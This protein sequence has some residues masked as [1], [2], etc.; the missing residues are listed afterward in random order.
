MQVKSNLSF[1]NISYPS[2]FAQCDEIRK[3]VKSFADKN[4][5]KRKNFLQIK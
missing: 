4:K 5:K 1:G 2:N 3:A